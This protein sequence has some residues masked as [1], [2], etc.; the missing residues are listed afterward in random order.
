MNTF[1]GQKVEQRN[2]TH[3]SSAGNL[4]PKNIDMVH[5]KAIKIW[6]I[7]LKAQVKN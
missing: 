6:N 4:V 7:K 5:L 3:A 1:L 2:R